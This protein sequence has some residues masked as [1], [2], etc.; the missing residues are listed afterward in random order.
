MKVM[1]T[2]GAGGVGLSVCKAFLDDGFDVR[3]FDLDNRVNQKRVR[4]LGA[5]T[6][7]V[8]GDITQSESVRRAMDSVDAVVHL[9]GIIQP[10]TEK[11]PELAAKV[12]VG[13]TQTIVS[14]VKESGKRIPF[15]FPSS[16]AVF[17][18]RPDLTECII[19]DK[20]ACNPTTVYAKNKIQSE[21]IIKESGI[22]YVILRL[23]AVPHM[24]FAI[25]TLRTEMYSIPL[26]NRFEFCHPDDVALAMLN[27]V[28]NF[29]LVKGR[30]L[31]I[32]G[33]PSQ[34]M[35]YEDMIGAFLQNFGLPLPPEHKFSS[36]PY[37]LHWYDTS[38]SQELLKFQCKTFEEYR[39]ET[40]KQF[41]AAFT[42]F[43]RYFIGPVFG[44]VIVRLL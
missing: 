30:T 20:V 23:T 4:T 44:R 8:W 6:D 9:A 10:L 5:S 3:V 18:P 2:G 11:N 40:S 29:Q 1:I 19:C 7:I 27:A 26:K 25:S 39:R 32:A 14:L 24:R 42:A 22:D 36:E 13:G 31:I 16:V 38:A 41:P 43:M 37:Y 17:G 34:Q 33:G 21:N 12:N 28:K 35:L 15:V